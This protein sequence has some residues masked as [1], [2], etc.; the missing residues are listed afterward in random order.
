MDLDL[1]SFVHSF[2]RPVR[3]SGH[4]SCA[5]SHGGIG[6]SQ[7]FELQPAQS[8]SSLQIVVEYGTGA[9]SGN[10]KLEGGLPSDV[11]RTDVICYRQ[12]QQIVCRRSDV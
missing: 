1:K 2:C 3:R 7:G 6:V 4:R 10:V 11:Q 5:S 12:G 9:I 8:V